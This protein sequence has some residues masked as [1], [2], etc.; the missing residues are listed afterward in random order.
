M[1]VA[2]GLGGTGVVAIGIKGAGGISRDAPLVGSAVYKHHLGIPCQAAVAVGRGAGAVTVLMMH[3]DIHPAIGS[4]RTIVLGV[5]VLLAQVGVRAI[6]AAVTA[7]AGVAVAAAAAVGIAIACRIAGGA[8]L[9]QGAIV[10]YRL[11]VPDKLP[12]ALR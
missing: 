4:V 3:V 12:V 10:G 1:T 5:Y 9:F 8:R 11:G 2:A 6:A 7:R